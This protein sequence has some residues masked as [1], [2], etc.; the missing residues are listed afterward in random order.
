VIF[1][2]AV[3][4]T[5]ILVMLLWLA[6]KAL[7]PDLN[8]PFVGS[9]QNTPY[10]LGLAFAAVAF[11]ALLYR[12]LLRRLNRENL[13]LGGLG[14][15]AV[16]SLALALAL[17]GSAY[18]FVLPVLV[19]LAFRAW[20]LSGRATGAWH[21]AGAVALPLA[22]AL[23]LIVPPLA[24]IVLALGTRMELAASIPVIGLVIGAF[25]AGAAGLFIPYLR[26]ST[27]AMRSRPPWLDWV[28]PGAAAACSIL[29]LVLATVSLGFDR[30]HPRPDTIN[31][32]LNADTGRA[33]WLTRDS[34]LDGYTRQF[35]AAGKRSAKFEFFA[36][37]T[38]GGSAADAPVAS[39]RGPTVR[40]LSR[41]DQGGKT[42]V[43]IWLASP[44]H[45]PALEAAISA[46]PITAASIDGRPVP[47]NASDRRGEL[48]FIYWELPA[49]G[50]P[51]SLK[52]PAGSAI[53]LDVHDISYG[54]P[55][56][57][58]YTYQPRPADTMS[59]LA[60]AGDAT[61][62]TNSVILPAQ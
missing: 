23:V 45:A 21:T 31:Y 49:R 55:R 6:T 12:P 19:A 14:F 13:A 54:L 58:G 9:Y 17:P 59:G 52:I 10:F 16:M 7:V 62:V 51:V 56:I 1:P 2:L 25:V 5:G 11:F 32:Q 20:A 40:L 46:G 36:M 33:S 37:S 18:L 57:P 26:L 8:V 35:F 41:A 4:A 43:R 60:F 39:L 30:S 34:S 44:R 48:K 38:V 50:I 28:I 3:V 27:G 53:T 61:M 24:V 22:V 29:L 47:L 42:F 15:G